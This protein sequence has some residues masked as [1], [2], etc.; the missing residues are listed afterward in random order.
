MDSFENNARELTQKIN[1][2]VEGS[3]TT[4]PNLVVAALVV[5]SGPP[6]AMI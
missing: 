5:L 4:L 6:M 3:I 1:G 2:W